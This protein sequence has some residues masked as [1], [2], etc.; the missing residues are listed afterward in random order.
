M[1]PA[2]VDRLPIVAV[3]GSGD[4]GHGNPELAEAVGR[5]IA[6]LGCHLL[7]GGGRGVMA[8][9][10]RGFASVPDRAGLS[11]GI[12]PRSAEDD[13]P[14]DGYPNPWVEVPILTHLAGR[15]GPDGEDS[16]N[17]INV[18]TASRIVALPGGEGTRAEVKLALRN[19]RPILA[20]LDVDRL[21]KE[22]AFVRFLEGLRVPRREVWREE[23]GWE[24]EEVRRFLA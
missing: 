13:G 22:I 23:D 16:R 17:A 1:E 12:I 14:K 11:L 21:A 15:L 24:L 20:V 5:L 6:T 4:A 3:I 10:C 18:L 9:A 19:G 8:D 7:T 2:L